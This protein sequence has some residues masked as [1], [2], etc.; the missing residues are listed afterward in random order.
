[1]ILVSALQNTST[2]GDMSI[3]STVWREREEGEGRGKKSFAGRRGVEVIFFFLES[4]YFFM[5]KDRRRINHS[6]KTDRL[7]WFITLE[8]SSYT[9]MKI[10]IDRLE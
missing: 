4:R 8:T 10:L 5:F 7:C 3:G 1:M 6:F 9:E 2:I